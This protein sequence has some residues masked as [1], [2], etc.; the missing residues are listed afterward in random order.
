M[1]LH[2]IPDYNSLG[3]LVSPNNIQLVSIIFPRGI[4]R[5]AA[6]NERIGQNSNDSIFPTDIYLYADASGL[7]EGIYIKKFNDC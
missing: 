3:Y 6:Y 4:F 2:Y 7:E 1:F 5:D